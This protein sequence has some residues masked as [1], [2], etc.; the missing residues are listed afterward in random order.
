MILVD[1]QQ[2]MVASVM[3]HLALMKLNVPEEG[4]VRHM[5]LNSLRSYNR[6]FRTEYG[7]MIICDDSMNSWRKEI[8]K[9]YKAKR[10]KDRNE[11]SHD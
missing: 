8:F 9:Y 4:M 7:E 2:V 11:S 10:Q 3:M 6:K 5:I 1:I